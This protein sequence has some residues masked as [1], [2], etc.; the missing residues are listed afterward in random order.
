MELSP[1]YEKQVE[2]IHCKKKF[3][4]MKVRSNFVKVKEN[5][6]DFQPI[7]ENDVTPFLYNVFVL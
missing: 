3:K 2:C 7:Y 6:S 5:T 4:S 1:Y